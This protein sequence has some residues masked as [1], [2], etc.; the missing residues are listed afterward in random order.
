[1]QLFY[2]FPLLIIDLLA[3]NQPYI[4]SLITEDFRNSFERFQGTLPSVSDAEF[5]FVGL[6]FTII[7][8]KVPMH[9]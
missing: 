1:M 5:L 7:Q 8:I 9:E 2:S 3:E 6:R 4:Y